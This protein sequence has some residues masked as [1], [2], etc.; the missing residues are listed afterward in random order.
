LGKFE[1]IRF[2]KKGIPACHKKHQAL[3]WVKNELGFQL[4]LA[5]MLNFKKHPCVGVVYVVN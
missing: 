2:A 5:D 4:D 1:S 3:P